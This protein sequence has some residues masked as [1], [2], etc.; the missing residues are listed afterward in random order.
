MVVTIFIL[1]DLDITSILLGAPLDNPLVQKAL[2]S[3]IDIVE[4]FILERKGKNLY[5]TVQSKPL[6]VSSSDFCFSFP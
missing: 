2:A 1:I 4:Y 5:L 3:C 6:Q